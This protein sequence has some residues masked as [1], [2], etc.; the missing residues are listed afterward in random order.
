VTDHHRHGR[1]R[2]IGL[3]L[4]GSVFVGGLG[5][6]TGAVFDPPSTEDTKVSETGSGW[7]GPPRTPT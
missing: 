4:A 2:V 6:V 5:A 7:T 3:V 1:R